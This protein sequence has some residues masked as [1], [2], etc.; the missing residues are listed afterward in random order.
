MTQDKA[1]RFHNIS[2]IAL[3]GFAIVGLLFWIPAIGQESEKEWEPAPLMI[4]PIIDE[5]GPFAYLAKPSTQI[6]VPGVTKGTQFTFDGALYNGAAELCF[7]TGNPL[8]PLLA[9]QKVMLDG[10]IPVYIYQWRDGPITYSIEVFGSLIEKGPRDNIINFIRLKIKNDGTSPAQAHLAAAIRYTAFDHRFRFKTT[11][12]FSPH[13][14]YEMSN[15]IIM[16]DNFLLLTLPQPTNK[17]AVPGVPYTAPFKGRDH[18]VSPRAECCL[19]HYQPELKGGEVVTL[20]FKMPAIPIPADDTTAIQA[21]RDAD[22]DAYRE[23]WVQY[24]RDTLEQ[25]TV[26]S[27]PEQKVMEAWRANLVHCMEAIWSADDGQWVQGVNKFQYNWFWLRDGAF[28]LR[29]YELLGHADLAAKLLPYF[30]RFQNDDGN[31]SSQ[32][33]Q[34]DGFG[35]ALFALGQHYTLTGDLDFAREVYPALPKAIN[36]LHQARANDEYGLMPPT[37]VRDNEYISGRYTGHNFWA[38]LGLRHAIILANA[39]EHLD[40]AK[41]FKKEYDDFLSA[42]FRRLET[43]CGKD[44]YIPAGLDVEGG[45]DWG[46]LLGVYPTEVLNPF[47]PRITTT[48]KKMHHEKYAEGIMTYKGRLHLYVTTNITETHTARGEQKEALI[49][50][51]HLLLH[52]DSTHAGFEFAAI[53]WGN[54][55]VG[56]NFPPH[57]WYAAKANALIRN[58]LVVERNGQ[59]GLAPRD[60]HFF[61]VISPTWAD[62]GMQVSIHNAPT[63][64]GPVSAIL[65]FRDDG[66]DFTLES[67]YRIRP[68][69]IILHIPFFV[70]LNNFTTD[71]K[72]SRLTIDGIELS[73]DVT[74]VELSWSRQDTLP[75]S[76]DTIVN[77]YKK[78]Y[79]RR[80]DDYRNKGNEPQPIEAPPMLT[81]E[82]RKSS[83]SLIDDSSDKGIAVG[84]PVET[85]G[86]PET[87]H[88]AKLIVDGNARDAAESSWWAGPPTPRWV[89][90]DLEEPVRINRI[91]VFPYWDY[92]RFYQYTVEISLDGTTWTQVADRSKNTKPSTPLGDLFSFEPIA[93]H[94]V[95]VTMLYNSANTSVHLVEVRVFPAPMGQK[96]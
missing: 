31:F 51:Y 10:W 33:G 79:Q 82:E 52:T 96:K 63:E 87:G 35:Q 86:P 76:Y 5:S 66:A 23:R 40:D 17:E 8:K 22:H 56:G 77:Q 75:L 14:T 90:I 61:S 25:G 46:N 27:I 39:T 78:E 38:L 50:L 1:K 45:E 69:R 74:Q 36:W 11:H 44:G 64:C 49:D 60:L 28:I 68:N 29:S 58:M 92:S 95:R 71:A 16:R 41:A 13:W 47:D 7:F 57:A 94:Y 32:K 80:Y 48:I 93:A 72:S 53:P 6:A 12:P 19:L 34:L 81:M 26:I 24:W 42:F 43:V 15:S 89:K 55:D 2:G 83:Y 54:R 62:P 59:G 67:H 91:H 4:D 9:R 18:F 85:D 65:Q 70:K 20:D 88:P 84:K 3:L 30:L 21:I 37:T 73:H